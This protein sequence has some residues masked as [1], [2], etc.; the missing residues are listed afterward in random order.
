MM[1]HMARST[2][3]YFSKFVDNETYRASMTAHLNKAYA[4]DGEMLFSQNPKVVRAFGKTLGETT[5]ELAAHEVD[6]IA[7]TSVARARE[8]ARIMQMHSAGIKTCKVMVHPDACEICAPYEGKVISVQDEV[9]YIEHMA[10][11]EGEA[12][13]KAAKEHSRQAMKGIPPHDF[14]MGGGGP[15]YHPQCRCD[16][17]ME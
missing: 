4:R 9:T 13:E 8:Q 15:I 12:W 10:G 11:L 7:R 3:W 14:S 1:A 2:N 6:R 16:T 5:K 17:V